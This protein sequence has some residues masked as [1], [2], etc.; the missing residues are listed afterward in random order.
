MSY[1]DIVVI[2]GL[3]CSLVFY[4]WSVFRIIK[5][6]GFEKE[7]NWSKK[8]YFVIEL[9]YL[10]ANNY[11]L[12]CYLMYTIFYFNSFLFMKINVIISFIFFLSQF[13]WSL[14]THLK[15]IY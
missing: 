6:V 3:L 5:V 9:L 2:F 1:F 14:F 12:I 11:Y 13:S 7:N 15:K 4:G 10:L 8:W